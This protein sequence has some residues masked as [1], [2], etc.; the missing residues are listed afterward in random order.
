V[1][2]RFCYGG[3]K[4]QGDPKFPSGRIF[5]GSSAFFL[6]IGAYAGLQGRGQMWMS[7]LNLLIIPESSEA[8]H[9]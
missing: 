4:S 5:W 1:L 9:A 2:I 7:V 3:Y 6:W 8:G